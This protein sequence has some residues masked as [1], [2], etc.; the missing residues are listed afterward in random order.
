MKTAT[1]SQLLIDVA[2]AEFKRLLTD[3]EN[4]VHKAMYDALA[5]G[6][7]VFY[8]KVEVFEG[9]L[10]ICPSAGDYE[11]C[12]MCSCSMVHIRGECGVESIRNPMP[13]C[14][15]PAECQVIDQEVADD[16]DCNERMD[17][18]EDSINRFWEPWHEKEEGT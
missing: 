5:H 16:I 1:E 11:S 13:G 8:S 10:V 6:T 2:N 9:P 3:Q 17:K 12:A 14:D 18:L 7:T 15:C 4:A